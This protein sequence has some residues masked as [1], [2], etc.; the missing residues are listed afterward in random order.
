MLKGVL[1]R[2]LE[3]GGVGITRSAVRIR[4]RRPVT[5]KAVVWRH[6]CTQQPW[7]GDDQTSGI[8][9]AGREGGRASICHTATCARCRPLILNCLWLSR[10]I[11]LIS[12]DDMRL[13]AACVCW[14]VRGVENLR[15][16]SRSIHSLCSSVSDWESFRVNQCISRARILMRGL[17]GCTGQGREHTRTHAHTHTLTHSSCTGSLTPVLPPWV[18]MRGG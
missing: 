11:L 8:R 14:G 17:H 3:R 4:R 7:P 9:R 15:R 16:R 18:G 2:V 13:L 10:L 12:P 5:G 1:R 6:V